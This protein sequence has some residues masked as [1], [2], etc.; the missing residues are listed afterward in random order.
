MK[1]FPKAEFAKSNENHKSYQEYNKALRTWFVA[2]GIGGPVLLLT[3]DAM[4]TKL[5]SKCLLIPVAGLFLLGAAVQI[6]IAFINKIECWYC[7]YADIDKDFSETTLG[8]FM[9]WLD[10]QFW[11]DISCDIVTMV[12]YLIAII[13]IFSVYV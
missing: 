10:K 2:F 6:F 13:L 12:T 9:L 5:S 3:R 4:L 11:I 7:Y 1:P 8:K